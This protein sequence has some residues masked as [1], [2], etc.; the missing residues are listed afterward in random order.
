MLYPRRENHEQEHPQG[1]RTTT[2]SGQSRLRTQLKIQV[3]PRK[4]QPKVTTHPRKMN[5]NKKGTI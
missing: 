3:L 2:R 4:R 1:G 5:Y